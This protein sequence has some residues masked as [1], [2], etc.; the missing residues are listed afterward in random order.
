M[1]GRAG[2]RV[3]LVPVMRFGNLDVSV[4]P[5]QPGDKARR[6]RQREDSDA[7]VAGIDKRNLPRS[8]NE[9]VL[10]RCR[11]PGC[12]KH[13]CTTL[14]G[15]DGQMPLSGRSRREVDRDC[16]VRNCFRR[17]FRDGYAEPPNARDLARIPPDRRVT[18]N[19]SGA[20]EL[21]VVAGCDQPRDGDAHAPA[22]AQHG[23]TKHG[24]SRQDPMFSKN[25]RT[26][27]RQVRVRGR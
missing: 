14:P 1:Q 15:A 13:K 8:A 11:K 23:N 21:T 19:R 2:W 18:A 6:L 16:T 4:L 12:P 22:R 20:G 7:H 10:V 17:G 26:P 25:L 3:N 5:D 27:S 24:C 9:C